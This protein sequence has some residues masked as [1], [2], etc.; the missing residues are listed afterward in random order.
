MNYQEIW[1]QCVRA[2][3]QDKS[4]Q[5]V[6]MWFD[7]MLFQ[8]VENGTLYILLP[9]DYHLE[10]I[11]KKYLSS[12][13]KELSA[14]A[15]EPLKIQF[16]VLQEPE[17]K[18][19]KKNSYNRL[20]QNKSYNGQPLKEEY[21]FDTFVVGENNNFAAG[22][23]RAISENPGLNYNPC[24]IYG[25]VGL[26]KT[27]LLQSIG[28]SVF[29]KHPQKKIVY[30]PAETFINEFI[31]SIGTK[32]QSHFK[33]KYRNVDILL[34]DD[35]HDLQN[36][37]ETQEELFHTFNSLYN[38]N[39]QMVF[40]CDRPAS[41][42]KNFTD[43][44]KNRFERGLNVDLQPPDYET[45]YAILN[46]KIEGLKIDISDNIIEFIAKNITTNVRD[47]EAAITKISAY[48]ELI[49]KNITFEIAKNQLQTML[50]QNQSTIISI[51][52]IQKVVA[53]HFNINVSDLKGKKRTKI[54]TVPRQIAMFII[55]DLTDY[56]TTE[57]GLEFGGRDHTTV[58]HSCQK[59]ETLIKTNPDIEP[60]IKLLIEKI[61]KESV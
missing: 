41:E 61:K 13:R 18:E 20:K 52:H 15:A 38:A 35:I 24:L 4:D 36:K 14:A 1:D 55:R 42:L 3:T 10:K 2:V 16:N 59:I 58:M 29:K 30:I 11:N 19:E 51:N 46:K 34:I 32:T 21:N 40:T 33:N 12:L 54:I 25:G 57:I 47:L 39:K 23:A 56:S 28:N 50:K 9:S 22:A 27:H 26:G 17:T 49:G 48:A 5:E 44:L 8:K 7:P 45:R 6:Q 60:L 31:Y 43:R 53:E 37:K